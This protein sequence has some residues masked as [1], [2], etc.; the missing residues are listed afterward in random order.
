MDEVGALV[1]LLKAYSPSG[2]EEKAVKAFTTLAQSLG[3]TTEVDAAGNAIARKGSRSPQVL[4][5]GHIDTVDGEVPVKVEGGRVYGRGAC[6]AKSALVAAL[7]A[8]SRHEGPG[9]VVVIGAVGEEKDSRGARYL[10][11]RMKPNALIVGEPSGWAG[12]TI[13][14]KGNLDLQF[15]FEGERT[16]LSSPAPTT[17]ELAIASLHRLQTWGSDHQDETAFK[18]LT[19]KLH[20]INTG[21]VGGREIVKVGVN[22]R[23]PTDVK[24]S[25][26]LKFLDSTDLKGKYKVGDSSDAVEVD[27]TNEVVRALVNGIRENGG[28]PILFKK[29]GTADMNLAVPVWGCPAAAYGPGDAHLDHTEQ[30]SLDVGELHRSIRVLEKALAILTQRGPA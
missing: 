21:R 10:I 11:P 26:A 20:S 7:F 3:F 4:F 28:E 25:D 23:L 19:H 16:H 5:L 22:V 6:D 17:V 9:E 24:V 30:E 27:R 2:A 12:V 1:E 14:Y 13:G 18:S 8:A 15:T 29:S